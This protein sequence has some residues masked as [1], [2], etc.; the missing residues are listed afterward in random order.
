MDNL[1][2]KTYSELQIALGERLRELRLRRNW[3]QR[4]TAAR[5]GISDRALRN[6]EAGRGSTVETLLRVMKALDALDQL[7]AWV[8]QPSVNPL[9]L[10]NAQ[11]PQ[12][13]VR[14]ARR[15]S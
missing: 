7:N 9:A 6:L 11:T 2:Y 14:R 3:D 8:P 1:S 10:L 4:D 5:A 13:R 12:R 15:G